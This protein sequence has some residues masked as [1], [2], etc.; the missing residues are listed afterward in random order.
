MRGKRYTTEDKIRILREAD[1]GVRELENLTR[2]L[3]LGA[4][5]LAINTDAVRQTLAARNTAPAPAGNFFT[6]FAGDFLARAQ[7]GE[8]LMLIPKCSS[9]PNAKSSP[10]PSCWPK[11]ARRKPRAGWTCPASPCAKNPSSLAC[12]LAPPKPVRKRTLTQ[13]ACNFSF[14]GSPVE[15]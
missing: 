4:R 5:G 7:Q 1:C 6:A 13:Q 12:I 9:R 8:L 15:L 3:L 11:A 2:R 14:A 10:K